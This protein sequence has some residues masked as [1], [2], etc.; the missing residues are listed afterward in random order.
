MS[1]DLGAP[2]VAPLP[3]LPTQ[4]TE[5]TPPRPWYRRPGFVLAGL[6]VVGLVIV[7]LLTV[8]RSSGGGG[9]QIVTEDGTWT[10]EQVEVGTSIPEGCDPTTQD[11]TECLAAVEGYEIVKVTLTGPETGDLL[12]SDDM[13][14]EA[15]DGNRYDVVVQ[16]IGEGRQFVAFTPEA[17]DE[18]YVLHWGDEAVELDA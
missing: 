11:F 14:L 1:V 9:D 16:S 15:S 12:N 4:P 13:Y 17:S 5:V 3:P 8:V 10:I 18:G 2:E 6:A 7:L